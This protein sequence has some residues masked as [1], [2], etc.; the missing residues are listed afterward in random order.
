MRIRS[1]SKGLRFLAERVLSLL[2]C[3]ERLLTKSELQ[4]ALAVR[5]GTPTLDANKRESV[6]IMV[7]ACKGLVIFEEDSGIIRLVHDTTRAYLATHMFC[8]KPQE[9][10]ATLEDPETSDTQKNADAMADAQN[11]LTAI[12]VTYLSFDAFESGLCQT[13][14]EFEER[15]RSNPLY[16]YAAHNWAIHARGA[17]EC[18]QSVIDF[19]EDTE[20]V[21]AST[22]ALMAAERSWGSRYS[23]DVSKRMTGLHLA[24][25]L[26]VQSAVYSLIQHRQ[27]VDPKD[28]YGRT[29][30]LYAAQEGHEG[31]VRQ[32]LDK[33]ADVDAKDRF[34]WTPLLCAAQRGHEAAVRQLLDKQADVEAK[35]RF[36]WT[37]LLCAAQRGHEA[38]VRQLLD[39]QADVEA[40]NRSGQTALLCAAEEGH[41]A[42]VRQLLDKHADVEAK[43]ENGWTALL[44]AALV[45]H[46]AVVKQLLVRGKANV[47]AKDRFGRTAL[48]WAARRGHEAVVKQLLVGGKADVEAKDESGRTALL[49]AAQGGHEAVMKLLESHAVKLS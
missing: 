2:T 12:C 40:K 46:E 42:V 45:G 1:Q 15:L 18:N 34:G 30:L 21:E 11:T 47:E 41:E 7:R 13:N 48:L 37:A 31:T 44:C 38:V 19:L 3:A 5:A 6:S 22:Q 20:K 25:Y 39:K 8:I 17:P 9:N 28:S 4:D 33:H 27:N 16:N 14:E 36:G 10:P 24:A 29:P 43:D 49:W 35:D 32:L 26:G 23:Q